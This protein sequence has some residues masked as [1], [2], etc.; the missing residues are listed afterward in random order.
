MQ[1]KKT[2]AI[3]LSLAMIVTIVLGN[4]TFVSAATTEA[5]TGISYYVD[6]V[7]GNDDNDGTSEAKA[8]KS[9]EKVNATTFKPGDELRFKRGCSWSGLLSPKGSGEK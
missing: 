3:L 6:S 7:N 5:I 9:L 1:Q 2:F 4:G 8:W